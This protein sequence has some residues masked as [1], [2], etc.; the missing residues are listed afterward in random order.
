MVSAED[1]NRTKIATLN[2]LVIDSKLEIKV[3]VGLSSF[4][5]VI[6][7]KGDVM[8][9]EQVAR[10]LGTEKGDKV[11]LFVD[12]GDM[13]P[14][15]KSPR[16]HLIAMMTAGMKNVTVNFDSERIEYKGIGFPFSMLGIDSS[17]EP[18]YNVTYEVKG[19]YKKAD[20]KFS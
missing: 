11:S 14:E 1:K 15:V 16:A 7:E 19:T 8:I 5:P 3:G 4:P 20:G 12:W 9:P 13:F 17:Q 18:G 2:M 10:Y 6:L